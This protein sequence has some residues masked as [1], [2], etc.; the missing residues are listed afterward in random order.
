MNLKRIAAIPHLSGQY[1]IDKSMRHKYIDRMLLAIDIG[2]TN[3][4][5]GVFDGNN[6]INH[7][8]IGSNRNLTVDESAFL[9][10]GLLEKLNIKP[11]LID[12]L[13]MASVVPTLTPIYEAMS[14]RYL[15]VEPLVV[16]CNLKMPIKIGYEDPSTVGADRIANAVAAFTKYAGP[17][18]VVDF[19]T[20]TTFDVIDENGV[21]LGGII[22]PGP[23]TSGAELAK[24]ASRL[25]EVG[26]SRPQKII[27]TN[28]ADSIRSG[29]F[30]GT[31][32]IVDYL[33]ERINSEL[34]K[35]ASVIGTGGLASDF[36]EHSNSIKYYEPTLTLDGLKKIAD[37]H[38]G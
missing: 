28:T 18:I 16:T 34:G 11:A 19:G 38:F 20:A 7:F 1:M 10:L 3:T 22:A 36:I 5:I 2:N 33:V 31:L 13:V 37:I 24:K 26:V 32:G 14:K 27:G 6:L 17:V 30:F 21:Y 4:V 29:L 23:E 15:A 9:V 35:T 12:R 25:F 8:R